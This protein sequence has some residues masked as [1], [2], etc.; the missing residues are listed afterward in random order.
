[1]KK[2]LFIVPSLRRAGAETQAVDLVNAIDSQLFEKYLFTFEKDL[3]QLDRVDR[4]S[5]R[6]FNQPRRSKY[7]LSMCDAIARLIDQEEIDLIHCT[8]QFSL[9]IGWVAVKRS[10]RRPPLVCAI[11]ITKNKDLKTELQDLALYQWLLRACKALIFVCDSQKEYWNRKF[12]ALSGKSVV[13][14]NGVDVNHF[15]ASGFVERALE[16][17]AAHSIPAQAKV[18]C[19]IAG[20]REEK[21]HFILLDAFRI[22]LRN[23]PQCYL[24]LA[25][26]GDFRSRIAAHAEAIGIGHRVIFTGNMSDVRPILAASDVKVLA[27]TSVETFSIAMLESMA[28]NV[29]VIS[30]SIGGAG[31]AIFQDRTGMLVPAADVQGLANA[32]QYALSEEGRLRRWGQACRDLVARRF[33]KQD[34]VSK[35]VDVLQR[36]MNT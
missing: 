33:S 2:I 20:F 15:M 30:T 11:H 4:D 35:T 9:L 29:P 17:R 23:F 12:P 26:D 6:F 36:A 31:E 21:G 8:M 25:G 24:V 14:H 19:C 7:D 1:M 22:V 34:M 32:M 28:M 16:F 5:V 10:K 27:S 13:V 18:F 3:S